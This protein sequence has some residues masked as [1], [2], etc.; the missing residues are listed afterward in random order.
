MIGSSKK[1]TTKTKNK[2]KKKINSNQKN[3]MKKL[4][5]NLQNFITKCLILPLLAA[6]MKW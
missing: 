4:K 1:N 3:N 2:K 6:F 5:R